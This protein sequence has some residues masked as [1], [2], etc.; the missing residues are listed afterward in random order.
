MLF[1]VA[2]N[3]CQFAESIR[4]VIANALA[5]AGV[6]GAKYANTMGWFWSRTSGRC[7]KSRFTNALVRVL[8]EKFNVN[9]M[10]TTYSSEWVDPDNYKAQ[11]V[12]WNEVD[13]L[14]EN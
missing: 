14:Y 9:A 3:V 7:G 4:R 13:E 6:E 12:V 8:R 10:A 1:P 11:L 5:E 2:K